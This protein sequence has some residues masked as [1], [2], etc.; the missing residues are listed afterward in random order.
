MSR[1]YW[2][3]LIAVVGLTL[4]VHAQSVGN[5]SAHKPSAT[6]G[7]PKPKADAPPAISVA[8]QDDI[9]RIARALETANDKPE[10]AAEKSRAEQDL[11]AQKD[12]VTWARGMFWAGVAE[13]LLTVAGVLLIWRTLRASWAA[14]REAKRAADAAHTALEDS[15][16]SSEQQLRA[17]VNVSKMRAKL[18]G[19]LLWFK[20]IF[21]NAG[22]TPAHG[23]RSAMNIW[24][25]TFAIANEEP[26]PTIEFEKL[27]GG[28]L[29]PRGR[30]FV[31]KPFALTE[32][33]LA[34]V[35]AYKRSVWCDGRLEYVDVFGSKKTVSFRC[36]TY[37]HRGFNDGEKLKPYFGAEGN[38]CN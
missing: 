21:V 36:R 10:S 16:I 35:Q 33:Q 37:L 29:E 22:Q 12:M 23:L 26:V 32:D 5:Q 11:Q 13:L 14:A 24:M 20:I 9:K 34:D 17:Y 28:T 18:E 7:A 6:Q 38:S 30:Y 4:P 19:N 2:L 1:R 8:V 27:E 25:D 3:P 31:Q 15:R